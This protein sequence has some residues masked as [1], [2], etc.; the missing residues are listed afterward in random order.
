MTLADASERVDAAP[1]SLYRYYDDRDILIYVGITGR[2]IQRNREHNRTKEWWPFVDR[3]EIEHF[4]DRESALERERSLIQ[5]LRPPF[6]RQHNP[7]HATD[8]LTYL[9][10]ADRMADLMG[11]EDVYRGIG[12]A[13]P[14]H[15]A[16]GDLWVT[17][18][19]HW[20]L[21]R[22]LPVLDRLRVHD[23][24]RG[25]GVMKRSRVDVTVRPPFMRIAITPRRPV[26][27]ASATLRLH[28]TQLPGGVNEW[29]MKAVHVHTQGPT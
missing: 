6:N 16:S 2:G 25:G 9:A 14:L 12:R 23:V 29:A 20:G 26:T 13:L 7:T 24:G 1:T 11:P 28:V 8:R 4:E 17:E 21:V 15:H 3:Q 10:L 18:P 22:V 27:I 19:E 5:G